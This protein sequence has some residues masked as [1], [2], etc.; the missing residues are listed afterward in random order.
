MKEIASVEGNYPVQIPYYAPLPTNLG[1]W[2]DSCIIVA[3]LMKYDAQL[4]AHQ[5]IFLL[6]WIHVYDHDSPQFLA[7]HVHQLDTGRPNGQVV[8]PHI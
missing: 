2:G 7:V 6:Y 4:H 5:W 8:T 1:G 3:F